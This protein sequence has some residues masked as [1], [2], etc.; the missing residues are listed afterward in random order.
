MLVTHTCPPPEPS[1]PVLATGA[2]HF[3]VSSTGQIRMT[4]EADLTTALMTC[5]GCRTSWVYTAAGWLPL[6]EE[7]E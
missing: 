1:P 7:T 2:A 6:N 3:V 4:W 5:P